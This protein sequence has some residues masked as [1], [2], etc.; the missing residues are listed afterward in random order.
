MLLLLTRSGVTRSGRESTPARKLRVHHLRSNSRLSGNAKTSTL[1]AGSTM[2]QGR[3]SLKAKGRTKNVPDKRKSMF[4]FYDTFSEW[5]WELNEVGWV[6]LHICRFWARS[7]G[8]AARH[9]ALFPGGSLRPG[10]NSHDIIKA[11]SLPGS[12]GTFI[13]E[14]AGSQPVRIMSTQY[15]LY[16]LGMS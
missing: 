5:K 4:Q 1:K 14:A 11:F 10:A 2:F 3:Q 9:P 8:T 16:W 7:P 15:T 6:L 12:L 13:E